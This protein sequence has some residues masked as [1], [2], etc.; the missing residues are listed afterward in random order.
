M[1]QQL[2]IV[3]KDVKEMRGV[4]SRVRVGSELSRRDMLQLTL[5]SSEN[6]AAASLAH[7][8]PGGVPAFVAAI[9]PRLRRWG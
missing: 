2:P 3:I 6:R 7:H 8:Y 5:M 4:F 9:M 1:D